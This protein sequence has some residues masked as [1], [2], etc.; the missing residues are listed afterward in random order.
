M[1][2]IKPKVSKDPKFWDT[3]AHT[4]IILESLLRRERM[5]GAKAALKRALRILRAIDDQ[6]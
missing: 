6:M 2:I 1:A 3:N 5:P 4:I